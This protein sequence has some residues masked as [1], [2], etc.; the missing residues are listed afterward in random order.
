MK[1]I[2]LRIVRQLKRPVEAAM[3]QKYLLGHLEMAWCYVAAYVTLNLCHPKT[4][5]LVDL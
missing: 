5:E 1:V 3:E 4:V 2:L